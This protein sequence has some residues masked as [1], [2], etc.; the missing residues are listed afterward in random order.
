MQQVACAILGDDWISIRTG[1][2]WDLR[3][4]ACFFGE[5][6][7]FIAQW[8]EYVDD[9][10]APEGLS[11][12]WVTPKGIESAGSFYLGLFL[13]SSISWSFGMNFQCR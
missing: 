10:A 5:I 11:S 9:P 12:T 3:D 6:L 2:E 4:S 1:K 13:V 7:D 8:A